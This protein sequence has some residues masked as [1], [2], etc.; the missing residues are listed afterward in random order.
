MLWKKINSSLLQYYQILSIL[1][2]YYKYIYYKFNYV[3]IRLN[4]KANVILNK[5]FQFLYKAI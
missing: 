4:I 2:L 5:I 3:A 1:S